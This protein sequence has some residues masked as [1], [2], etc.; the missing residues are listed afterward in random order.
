MTVS[1]AGFENFQLISDDEVSLA[2]PLGTIGS[3]APAIGVT[4]CFEMLVE[5]E[6]VQAQIDTT[7]RA[8]V[9]FNC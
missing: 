5:G 1:N 8:K 4:S 7:V 6:I 2:F 3:A 9:K